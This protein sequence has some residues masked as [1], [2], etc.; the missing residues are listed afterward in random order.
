MSSLKDS[1]EKFNEIYNLYIDKIYRFVFLKI[2][3]QETAEDISSDVFTRF[4]LS[5]DRGEEI[6]NPQA[7]VYQIARNLVSDHY[8]QNKVKFVPVQNCQEI[9]DNRVNLEEE[10]L[11]KSDFDR[12]KLALNKIKP[13][14]QDLIIFHYLDE[15]SVPEIA[16]IINKSEGNVRV[17]LHRSLNALK[18]E[19]K[20]CNK[21]A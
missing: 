20:E 13:E 15:L 17:A 3:S 2:G 10:A 8:R 7:F 5:L 14:Y 19:C 18:K 11:S 6:K 4:W 9:E 12:I 16:K 1:K 21:T